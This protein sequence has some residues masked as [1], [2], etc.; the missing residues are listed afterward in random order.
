[1][2]FK[3]KASEE[4]KQLPG[5]P[6]EKPGPGKLCL[7]A[8]AAGVGI[9]IAIELF[10]L[11][12]VVA[13]GA[14]ICLPYLAAVIIL[15]PAA[16]IL[17]H[18]E[19]MSYER[20][21]EV[22]RSNAKAYIRRTHRFKHRTPDTYYL[23]QDSLNAPGEWRRV[24]LPIADFPAGAA[25]VLKGEKSEWHFLGI[26]KDSKI[27]SVCTYELPEGGE[28]FA[29]YDNAAAAEKCRAVEGFS[30]LRL[31]KKPG[32]APLFKK[33][34]VTAEHKADFDA[35]AALSC[36][37]SASTSMISSARASG[38]QMCFSACRPS[39]RSAAAPSPR[40]LTRSA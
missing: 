12:M 20:I 24:E 1:M 9:F 17:S 7:Y 10:K 23:L 38:L 19:P 37:K 3:S 33:P 4:I 39:S 40:S 5:K 36:P 2:K 31:I 29:G 8:V 27:V 22:V 32:K 35:R 15:V 14:W 21:Q 30:V 18:L 11:L 26:E 25:Y 16:F 34:E 13:R 6:K 28:S